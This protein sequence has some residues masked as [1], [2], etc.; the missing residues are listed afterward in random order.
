MG[1]VIEFKSSWFIVYYKI[2]FPVL[3]QPSHCVNSV[4]IYSYFW[5]VS[6]KS[7]CVILRCIQNHVRY[8]RWNFCK[9]SQRLLTVHY[10]F[11]TLY[12]RYLRGLW[13]RLRHL[14]HKFIACT[15]NQ[16]KKGTHTN[17][18]FTFFL[19]RFFKWTLCICWF[20]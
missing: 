17:K 16:V 4:Q 8:L 9:N 15:F 18:H 20:K 1:K 3:L 2:H 5:S 6:V 7:R 12:F 14:W 19:R 11:K 13:I 10:I